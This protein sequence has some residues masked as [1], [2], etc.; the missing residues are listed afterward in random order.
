MVNFLLFFLLFPVCRGEAGQLSL[1]YFCYFFH[2][3]P[4]LAFLLH[5]SSSSVFLRYLF[6]QPSNLSYGLESSLHSFLQPSCFFVSD[7]LFGNLS[8]FI[9]AMCPAHFIRLFTILPTYKPLFQLFL[10]GLSF[11]FSPLSVEGIC[12]VS[13]VSPDCHLLLPLVVT[14]PSEYSFVV[15]HNIYGLFFTTFFYSRVPVIYCCRCHLLNIHGS[16]LIFMSTLFNTC[17]VH[18]GAA[19]FSLT[20]DCLSSGT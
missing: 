18:G 19:M 13:R 16:R 15:S 14:C 5:F 11:S 7:D 20:Q 10:L 6:R 8:Y 2:C 4:L 12:S 17:L 9:L 1:W 3:S